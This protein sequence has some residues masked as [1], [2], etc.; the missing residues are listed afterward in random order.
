MIVCLLIIF[1]C[2]GLERVRAIQDDYIFYSSYQP[3]IKIKINTDF[4][5]VEEKEES[6]LGFDLGG[7]DKISNVK[8]ETYLFSNTPLTK[9]ILIEFQ[10]MISSRWEFRGN[11]FTVNN[12]LNSG[13]VEI[14]RIKYQY[15]VYVI[16]QP[17]GNLLVKSLGRMAGANNNAF[18]KIHYIGKVTGDWSNI[19]NL[20]SEQ[21]KQLLEFIDA[22][23][24]DIQ[25]LK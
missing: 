8:M 25:I 15:C 6:A 10:E 5:H 20:N 16:N 14:N 11:L 2:A 9:R 3:K 1:S 17:S 22:S 13:T 7:S 4:K 12:E 18:I 24:K 21:N 23:K 19:N